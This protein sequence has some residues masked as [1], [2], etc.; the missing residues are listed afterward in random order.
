M[1]E[2][3]KPQ[4]RTQKSE[5]KFIDETPKGRKRGRPK[6]EE[7]EQPPQKVEKKSP[8]PGNNTTMVMDP[9]ASLPELEEWD[10]SK[11]PVGFFMVL[12]GKRRTGKST[13]LKW[14][15]QWYQHKFSLVWVMSQTAH[16]GYW[17]PF[18]GNKFV[19]PGWNPTAVENL[20]KRNMEIVA[21]HGEDSPIAHEI[22]HSLIILDD[23]ITQEIFTSDIFISQDQK[24][25][26]PKVRDN[27]DVAVVFNQKTF[28]NK[29]SIW[30]DFMND[31]D[32]K[33][34]QALLARYAVNHDALVCEQTNLDGTITK[35]FFKSTGDKTKL[36][37]PNYMLGGPTQKELIAKERAEKK[38]AAKVARLKEAA[39]K[40]PPSEKAEDSQKAKNFTVEKLE[41]P[42]SDAFSFFYGR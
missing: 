27:A 14:F 28:R 17:Q 39:D 40:R 23:C 41:R 15:L 26:C 29:E 30:H 7:K 33:T 10:P 11:L 31:V 22:G 1:S 19:F 34:A 32:K 20:I 36:Q 6:K 38:E 5:V 16:S 18:V 3:G 24:T 35:N 2:E 21:Q 37:N 42:K 25:V 13:F 9:I 8:I 12:E 4:I